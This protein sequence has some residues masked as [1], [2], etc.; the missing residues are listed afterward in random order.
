MQ[1]TKVFDKLVAAHN[2]KDTKL[3]IS[4]GS[5]S[6]SKTVSELQLLYLVA[7]HI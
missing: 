3:I 5:S 6:S 4:Y 1:T 2:D 7:L